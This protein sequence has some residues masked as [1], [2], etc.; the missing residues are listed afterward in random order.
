MTGAQ[1]LATLI[2]EGVSYIAISGAVS[3]VLG[4]ILAW[5]VLRALNGVILFFE[6]RFQ[7]LPFVIVLPVLLLV[8]ALAPAVCYRQM[9]K[10]SVVER[11]REE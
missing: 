11:L 9:R 2:W 8:A 10:K 3:F 4:S 6:Y 5:L 1:L 7:I